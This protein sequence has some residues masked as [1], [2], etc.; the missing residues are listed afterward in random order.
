MLVCL[1]YLRSTRLS[2]HFDDRVD[3]SPTAKPCSG[4]WLWMDSEASLVAR[5]SISAHSKLCKLRLPRLYQS[6]VAP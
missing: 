1:V 3:S 6:F 5:P 2:D 4:T